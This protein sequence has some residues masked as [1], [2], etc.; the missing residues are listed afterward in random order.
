MAENKY[1]SYAGLQK[2]DELIK[3]LMNSKDAATL[4]AAKAYVDG[5]ADNYEA[6]GAVATAKAELQALI[7][8]V[9]ADIEK[10]NGDATVEGSVD[11]KV[12]DVKEELNNAISGV[13]Q[14]A[15]DAQAAADAAQDDVDALELR[16]DAVEAHIGDLEAL[17]TTAK[18]DLVEAINEVR[19]AVTVGGTAAAVTMDSTTTT[20]GMLKSYTIKQG[21]NVVGTIDI[22]KDMVVQSGE[23]VV[24]ADNEVEGYAAGTY[25]KLVLANATN[26]EIYVNVGTLVDIYKAQ[27]NAAQV[28]LTIDSATREISAVIVAGSIGTAE[29]ADG[30]VT[31]V[32]IA[33]GNVTKAK[34]STAVQDSLDKADAAA[35]KAEFDEEVARAK[36][37]E[38]QA[39][40]DAKAYADEK[41]LAEE[42]RAKG[43]ESGLDER[44][45]AV[46]TTL[47]TGEGSVSEQIADAKA[48][49]VETAKNYTDEAI[50]EAVETAAED[51]I[52]NENNLSS[53]LTIVGTRKYAEELTAQALADAKEDSANKDAV[54]LAEAQKGINAVEDAFNSHAD[55]EEIHITSDER[56]LWNA[57]LQASD[58]ATGTA[59]GAISV[60]GVDVAVN[61][62]GS[63]AYVATTAFDTAGSAAQALTD[64]NSYTDAAIAKF[65]EVSNEDIEKLFK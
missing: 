32:K 35:T 23:V 54:V 55:N 2:Y 61:G 11:K 56:T 17:E 39:L 42:N 64:A 20:N 6:S 24:L 30:A 46:E 27:A 37:A 12:A 34:L 31:T 53:E 3:A 41:V 52:G 13:S 48:E 21:D 58:I 62:L 14:K 1:L 59:N 15:D 5:L 38:A 28:Q 25:I 43:V 40:T 26:D 36:A 57:A 51:I 44:L 65:E 45:Q 10:L 9:E 18:D 49:A 19:N 16:V 47:G 22:P 29:L 4:E 7:D 63:A 60:N 33:D 50:A 8:A